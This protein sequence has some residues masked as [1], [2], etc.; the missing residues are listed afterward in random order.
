VTTL[1]TSIAR[2]DFSSVVEAANKGER[3]LLKRHG[4]TMAAVVPVR[5][6]AVLRAIEDRFDR[7]AADAAFKDVEANGTISWDEMKANL[8]L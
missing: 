3:F 6:L 8:G 1:D 4:K 2:R 7:E 5:D